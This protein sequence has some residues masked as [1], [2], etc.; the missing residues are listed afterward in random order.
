MPK[1]NIGNQAEEIDDGDA[2]DLTVK[3]DTTVAEDITSL[4]DDAQAVEE[5]FRELGTRLNQKTNPASDRADQLRRQTHDVEAH[6]RLARNELRQ[7]TIRQGRLEKITS[8]LLRMPQ[9]IE[10]TGRAITIGADV[11][12]PFAAQW[13]QFW[14]DVQDLSLKNLRRFGEN[15]QKVGMRLKE[16]TAPSRTK[17][18]PQRETLAGFRDVEESWCPEMVVIPAGSFL[19]G[20]SVDEKDRERWEGPQREVRFDRP[21]AL[22]RFLITFEQFDRFCRE[23]MRKKPTDHGWGRRDRPAINV[24]QQDAHEF[25][26]WLSERI[27]VAYR[28]PS[29]A[30]WEYACRAGTTTP[31][32]FGKTLSHDQA[33]FGH[34]STGRTS[35]VGR[36]Q[37]NPWG[38]YD[39]HG[40]VA[41]WC[42]D[43]WH[44]SYDNA[45]K[46]GSAWTEDEEESSYSEPQAL[47]NSSMRVVRGGSWLDS[48]EKLRS[49][50]RSRQSLGMSHKGLGFRCAR[51]LD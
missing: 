29:E 16:S 5:S 14:I 4:G 30:E 20:S 41:E 7:P 39:M 13:F 50:A 28:L 21:Y 27:Q 19:M 42:V 26:R 24:S 2:V 25:C 47:I 11:L 40:N 18:S 10:S 23:T 15:L 17:A 36:Y 33:N 35:P 45:P 32:A 37:P 9:I 44:P 22:G 1:L 34:L 12:E 51:S 38:I 6:T 43:L 3:P 49:A 31:Y 8:V 46:D 48:V